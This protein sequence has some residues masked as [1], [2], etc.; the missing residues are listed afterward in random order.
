M[1]KITVYDDAAVVVVEKLQ[2]LAKRLY[3]DL[4]ELRENY[5]IEEDLDNNFAYLSGALEDFIDSKVEIG[6]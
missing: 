2:G 6:E 1:K 5:I 3:E 4:M